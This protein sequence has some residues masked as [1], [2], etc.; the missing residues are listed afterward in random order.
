[1]TARWSR[2][3]R[4]FRTKEAFLTC[5]LSANGAAE[6]EHGTPAA[7]TRPSVE[8]PPARGVPMPIQNAVHH[9]KPPGP[10]PYPPGPP[11]RPIPPPAQPPLPPVGGPVL[12]AAAAPGATGTDPV[13]DRL[14][15]E[16]IVFLGREVD[17]ELAN[18]IRAQLLL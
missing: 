3:E 10:P 14:L 15:E 4:T 8:A 17:D 18:R 1:M 5:S 9:P 13:L 12:Y 7:G 16:R 6:S 11:R 2:G